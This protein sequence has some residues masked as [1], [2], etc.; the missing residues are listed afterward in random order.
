MT[1]FS[2]KLLPAS[3]DDVEGVRYGRITVGTFQ[4]SFEV[5]PWEANDSADTVSTQWYVALRT[6]LHGADYVALRTQALRA[7]MLYRQG[8]KVFVQDVLLL[9]DAAWPEDSNRV[10]TL[11]P[12]RTQ[13]DDGAPV[14]EWHTTISAIRTFLA[15]A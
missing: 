3:D 7:W 10:N 14:S 15:Q 12:R 8:E 11:P 2:I 13:T 9:D 4:E 5:C 6:L 1:T